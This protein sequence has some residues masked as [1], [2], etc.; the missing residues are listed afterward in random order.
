MP[1]HT[2]TYPELPL[3][4]DAVAASKRRPLH[5]R[6]DAVVLVA[7]GGAAGTLTRYGLA[8]LETTR[9]GTWPWGTFLAN[10]IGAFVLGAALEWLA[11]NGPDVGWR[12]RTRLLIGTGFCGGLTTYSTFAVEA[13][14]LVRA[15][16]DRLA[17]TY[18]VLSLVGGLM[19]TI[20]GIAVA[21]GQH[22]LRRRG[23]A[24]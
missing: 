15:H 18:L 11:R 7:I 21:T 2:D 17:L 8:Q 3:D 16:H 4:P 14:L 23:A 9:P 10:I 5:F 1:S 13:D 19:A 22:H 6:L 20:A 24:A 12:Q